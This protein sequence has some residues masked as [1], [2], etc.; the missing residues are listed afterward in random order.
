VI[1]S[2][3]SHVIEPPDLWLSRVPRSIHDRAPQLVAD[4]DADWWYVDGLKLM[5]VHGGADVGVRF[6]DQAKLRMAARM[7]E[8]RRGGYEPDS[9]LADMDA[10]GVD[11]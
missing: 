6:E 9:K 11:R 1:V 2:T 4:D 3:D 7:S 8:V 5:S 10:D